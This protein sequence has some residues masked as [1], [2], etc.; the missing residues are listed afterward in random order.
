MADEQKK[1]KSGLYKTAFFLFFYLA[2]TIWS[3]VSG[4][5]SSE[6]SISVDISSQSLKILFCYL[7]ILFIQLLPIFAL[8]GAVITVVSVKIQTKLSYLYHYTMIALFIL[9]I[10]VQIMALK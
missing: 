3:I 8:I 7:Y 5:C 10:L 4:N 1:K 9:A 6:L 2:V